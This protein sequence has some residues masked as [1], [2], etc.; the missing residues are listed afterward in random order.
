MEDLVFTWEGKE[1]NDYAI[2][3]DKAL[4]FRNKERAK[5]FAAEFM[6]YY[7]RKTIHAD[8]NVGYFIGY[9]DGKSRKRLHRLFKVKH[10]F[11]GV[12]Y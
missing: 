8:S 10:P 2:I 11:F 3:M 7:R 4:R 12:N 5:K 1:Y 9:Y 6:A